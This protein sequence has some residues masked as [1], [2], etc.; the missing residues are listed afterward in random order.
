MILGIAGATVALA[1]AAK[2]ARRRPEERET[3]VH[4]GTAARRV[5][6]GDVRSAGPEGMRRE[7]GRRWN[8]TDQASDESFPAS[9]PPSTY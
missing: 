4:R 6:E 5:G 9:D 2:L 8:A 1:L 3:E 7:A